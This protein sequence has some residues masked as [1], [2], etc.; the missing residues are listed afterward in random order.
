MNSR[1]IAADNEPTKGLPAVVPPSGRFIV[2]LFLVPFVIVSTIV[3]LLLAVNWL[4][5]SSRSAEGFLSK[6]DSG[7]PDVRWRAAEDLAQVLLRNEQLAS[8]PKFALDLTERLNVALRIERREAPA[9][10]QARA[11]A[12]ERES[13]SRQP[14]QDYILYLSACLGN[15]MIPVGAPVISDM[16]LT[17]NSGDSRTSA[18]SRWRAIWVLANLGENLGRFH[19]LPPSRQ[20]AIVSQLE[21]EATHGV[22]DRSEWA[23][24][25]LHY[26][27]GTQAHSLNAL[28]VEKALL[29]CGEDNDPFLREITAFALNFW[30]G[31][32][33]EN[34]HLENLLSKLARD[35]GHGEEPMTNR[36]ANNGNEGYSTVPGLKIRYNATVAL[37]RRGSGRVRMGVLQEMLNESQQRDYFRV[38]TKSGESIPDEATV[39]LVVISAL[40]A[41]VELHSKKPAQD[42]SGLHP[43]I[44]ALTQSKSPPLY[45]EAKKTLAALDRT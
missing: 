8:D 40:R 42:L 43:A 3:C 1:T 4:V 39:N 44:E 25:A 26:L 28:G 17:Q 7:N 27:T 9:A 41:I 35:D 10:V 13:T 14:G 22:S 15:V 18:R 2:Q 20:E 21:S 36:E 6:L 16:A 12:G 19:D 33:E 24:M 11:A 34:D 45:N 29:Q 38:R 30:V 32:P 31:L 23:S 5:G 37:A